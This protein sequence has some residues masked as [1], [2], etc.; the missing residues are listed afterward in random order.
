MG[1]NVPSTLSREMPV[2]RQKSARDTSSELL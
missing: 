1:A 2:A